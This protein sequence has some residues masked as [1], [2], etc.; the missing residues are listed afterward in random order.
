MNEGL[1]KILTDS[2]AVMGPPSCGPCFGGHLGVL[3]KDERAVST[4]NRNFVGRMG[5]KKSEV[6]LSNPL[7]A[8]SSAVLGN[9]GGPANL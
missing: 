7:V 4:T 8:A 1:V 3:A 6:Y 5:H 9:I 2:G